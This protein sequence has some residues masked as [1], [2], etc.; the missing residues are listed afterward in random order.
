MHDIANYNSG[1]PLGPNFKV[2]STVNTRCSGVNFPP[3]SQ[4]FQKVAAPVSGIKLVT[5]GRT[6]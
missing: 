4:L 6:S 2:D 3:V 1:A 5:D